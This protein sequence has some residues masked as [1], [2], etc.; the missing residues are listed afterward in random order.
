MTHGHRGSEDLARYIDVGASVQQPLDY[1]T[2]IAGA[3]LNGMR[4][5]TRAIKLVGQHGVNE[6]RIIRNLPAMGSTDQVDVGS[7]LQQNV[8]GVIYVEFNCCD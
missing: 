6:P 5:N 7:V 1:E 8:D 4:E 3:I 2:R